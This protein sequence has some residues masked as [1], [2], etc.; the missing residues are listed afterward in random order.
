MELVVALNFFENMIEKLYEPHPMADVFS[1]PKRLFD[2]IVEA[3][4]V[5]VLKSL[6][7]ENWL[8]TIVDLK[9][10]ADIGLDILSFLIGHYLTSLVEGVQSL[11][12]IY[13]H[14]VVQSFDLSG[15]ITRIL[16]EKHVCE[17]DFVPPAPVCHP[18]H[19]HFVL[20]PH[21]VQ[22]FKLYLLMVWKELHFQQQRWVFWIVELPSLKGIT[23]QQ[24]IIVHLILAFWSS[25][26]ERQQFWLFCNVHLNYK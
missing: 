20:S 7:I 17:I 18:N 16:K 12:N 26:W 19:G 6:E 13:F 25:C 5:M 9:G 15:F 22:L 10:F 23:L 8:C 3:R 21:V 11:L 2:L 14:L 24:K 1:V 4:R